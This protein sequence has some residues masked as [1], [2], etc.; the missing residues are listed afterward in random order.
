[1]DYTAPAQNAFAH[2][3]EGLEDTW[4]PMDASRKAEYVN[5]SPGS[6][7]FRVKASNNDG[8]WNEQGAF[9]KI[10]ILPPWWMTWWFRTL[11]VLAVI[12]LI[13]LTMRLRIRRAVAQERIRWQIA[14]DL[15]DDVGSSLSSI[16]LV[17]ENVRNALGENHPALPELDSVTN[18]ARQ[19]ADRLK[20][21]VWVIKPGS[22]SLDNLLLRMKDATRAV[23]GHIPYTF[24]LDASGDSRQVPLAF[25][26]NV[27]L[28][29]KEA[30]HN[31]LK[32]SCASKVEISVAMTDGHFELDLADNGKGFNGEETPKGNG[33]I[34]MRN[35]AEVLK[36]DLQIDS[37]GARGTRIHL[38]VRIP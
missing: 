30:L 18:A 25:R 31:V 3:L 24:H 17:S 29:Y 21:D 12:G 22:D 28:I 14:S 6:Y 19:A 32:H 10:T 8:V 15:H 16:A 26:R 36:G 34:N 9:V 7:V 23:I 5:L 1:M 33:L 13:F 35:R 27:L 4:S 2:R 37:A 20:D 11:V 38:S